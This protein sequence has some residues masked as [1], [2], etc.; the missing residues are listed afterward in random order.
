MV[1][2]KQMGKLFNRKKTVGAPQNIGAD[3]EVAGN[4]LKSNLNNQNVDLGISGAAIQ[5][6]T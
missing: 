4:P 1:F 6:S 3:N 2:N 5:C